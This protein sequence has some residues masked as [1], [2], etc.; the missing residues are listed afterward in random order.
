MT[1]VYFIR[2]A[3]AEG[4]LYR[5]M[6]G[7]YDGH[8]TDNGRRQLEFLEKRF[9]NIR[10]DAVYSSDLR[11]AIE[12]AAAIHV[13]KGLPLHTDP[14]L[15]E[16]YFG[17]V[18]DMPW[19]N[20]GYE[21]PDQ[22]RYFN[23][24]PH[25]FRLDGAETIFSV[26]R[27]MREAVDEIVAANPGK[28]AAVVT[29]GSALRALLADLL[30]VPAEKSGSLGHSENTAVS[31]VEFDG[32]SINLIYKNDAGH[33]P[34][35]MR[36]LAKQSWWKPGQL[37]KELN[38]RFTPMDPDECRRLYIEWRL[39]AWRHIYNTEDGCDPEAFWEE[40]VH[41]S[42]RR[43]ERLQLCSFMDEPAGVLQLDEDRYGGVTAGHI[44]F[45]YLTPKYRFRHLGVQL[46]GEAVSRFRREGRKALRLCVAYENLSAIRFYEKN[47]FRQVGERS[48]CF[49][50]LKLMEKEI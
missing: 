25:L 2:H 23:E 27:R 33:L 37:E 35:D 26:Q 30:G 22:I 31:C 34:E 3:E 6:Q 1:R 32:G 14:R 29:H 43:P 10:I 7:H 24:Q 12:T 48:G 21:F 4:N 46:I 49:G 19:G 16:F 44:S 13:P 41:L 42:R 36:T 18:E 38:I 9:K 5:R 40:A 20:A 28:T 47:G 15:R 11:R 50:M 45:C 17:I 39:D 8:L